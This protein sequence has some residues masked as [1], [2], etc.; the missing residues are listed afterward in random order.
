[1]GRTIIMTI[2]A[3]DY[4]P[5]G[6]AQS[7]AIVAAALAFLSAL[8]ADQRE[9]VLFPF[10]P[11]KTATVETF[12]GGGRGPPEGFVG[13]RYGAAI[14]SHFPVSDV[15][16]AGLRLGSLTPA[17]QAAAMQLLRLILSAR[18]YQK[19][20]DIMAA[21]QVLADAGRSF[22][23]G[24][25]AYT[26]GIHGPPTTDDPW[27][28]Q[29][30]GHH[31]AINVVIVGQCVVLTPTLTGAQPAVFTA[32]DRRMRLF[33]DE[34][35]KAFALLRSLD[36]GQRGQAVLCS[37]IGD[38]LLGTGHDGETVAPQ[39][40]KVSAMTEDQ[41]VLLLDVIVEWAGLLNAAHAMPRLEEIRTGL[42]DT[43]FAWSGPTTH[44]PGRNGSGYYRIHGPKLW[45]EFA[46]QAGGGDPTNHVHTI[47]RDPTND[48]GRALTAPPM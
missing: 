48:Y 1:M 3:W 12:V 5:S 16:R 2:S 27:M 29:F 6:A 26:L 35:D 38:L 44:Q 20:R 11:Q 32:G 43:Y 45:I 46:P 15:P 8:R 42:D 14:W 41:K 22:V 10:K 7:A 13:E 17:Q 23:N 37:Q 33:A 34:N 36:D 47:Y 40:L 9:R 4:S 31:L 18:G 30:T 25:A 39:G 21:D 28:V 24:V 19:V